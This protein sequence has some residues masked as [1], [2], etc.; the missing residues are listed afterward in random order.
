MKKKPFVKVLSLAL[1]AIT[2]FVLC[3]C[4]TG[5]SSPA[6]GP[7]SNAAP[8]EASAASNGVL[9]EI[10]ASGELHITLSPDFAPMEF[11]DS[12]KDGQEQYVGLDVFLAKYIADYI[13]VKLVIEPMSFDACQTAV[14]TASVPMSVSGYVWTEERAES[15]E[16]SDY[17]YDGDNKIEPVILIRTADAEKYTSSEDFNGVDIGAQNASLQMQLVTS[18]LPDANPVAVG[19]VGTGVLELQNGSIEALAVAKGN[20]EII[21]DANPDLV[22]CPWEFTITEETE[23]FVILITKG[24]TAL[25]NVVNEALAKAYSEGMYGAWHDEAVALAKVVNGTEE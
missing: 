1:A 5:A 8:T 14:Y 23:A 4:G 24:E 2:L 16:I 15:Y 21:M 10:K 3:A 19:D 25:L 20:A 17:Y 18:Q 12:S 6:A 13:G 22:L 9:D 7:V 11:I